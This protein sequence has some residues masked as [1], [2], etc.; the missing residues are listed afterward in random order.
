[1]GNKLVIQNP[2]SSNIVPIRAHH[3]LCMQGFQ[4]YGYNDEFRYNLEKLVKYLDS[5]PHCQIKVVADADVICEKCPNLKEE[6][7]NKPLSSGSIQDMDITVLNKLKIPEGKIETAQNLFYQ[8][9]MA[10]N[11]DDVCGDCS[12]QSKCLWYQSKLDD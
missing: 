6:H 9:N 8:V 11:L 2:G 12:W 5:H 4:G 1:M 3:L 7:C 10:L